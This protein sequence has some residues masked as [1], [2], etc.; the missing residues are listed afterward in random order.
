MK[1][2]EQLSSIFCYSFSCNFFSLL[3]LAII[4]ISPKVSFTQNQLATHGGKG[5]NVPLEEI[6][7]VFIENKGQFE[8]KAD[9]ETP[10]TILYGV[11]LDGT[12]IYFTSSG[13][14]YRHDEI[15]KSEKRDVRSEKDRKSKKEEEEEEEGKNVDVKTSFLNMQ[16][17][18][19]TPN[20]QITAQ[21]KVSNYFTYADIKDITGKSTITAHACKKI[22]YKN[23]Y[24][25]TDIEYIFPEGKPG[26][27]YTIILHP[28]ADPDKIQ[29]HYEGAKNIQADAEGNIIIQS[30]LEILPIIHL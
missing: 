2:K 8:G 4:S 26:I 17:I 5:W 23:I 29:M 6:N 28:G 24:P 9:P 20:V 15:V 7:K 16:W 22:T 25:N 11:N 10:G 1:A 21:E 12:A 27:K 13:I 14:T 30:A 3:C 18:G 19:A